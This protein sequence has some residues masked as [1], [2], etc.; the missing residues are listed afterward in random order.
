MNKKFV[1]LLL[2]LI[3]VVA[4]LYWFFGIPRVGNPEIPTSAEAI[5]SGEYLY[6]AAGCAACHQVDG[7]EG[8]IG[9]YEIESPFGGSFSTPNITPDEETGIGGWTGRDFLL[10]LKHGRS[11]GGGFYWPSFPWRSYQ[12]MS[13]EEVLNIAAYMITLPP[14]NSES[15]EHDLPIWQYSWMTP[16]W[17]I[18]ADLMEGQPPVVGNDPQVQRGA[19]LARHFSHCGE[20]HTPRNFWEFP[21]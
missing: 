6:N 21:S 14:I 3:V 9:G 2:S 17:N 11:P 1:S 16:G 4:G 13:D 18:L 10:A 20:C 7:A 19:H 8:P 12:G 5:A 15:P